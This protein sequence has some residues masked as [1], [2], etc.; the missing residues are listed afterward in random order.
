M[1][2]LA[3]EFF[4]A[5]ATTPDLDGLE[6]WQKEKLV[7]DVKKA[8]L[9]RSKRSKFRLGQ[10]LGP[11]ANKFWPGILNSWATGRKVPAAWLPIRTVHP[12]AY[13]IINAL[14]DSGKADVQDFYKEM[15]IPATWKIDDGKVIV[16]YNEFEYA[17]K[18]LWVELVG[19]LLSSSDDFPFRRC[20]LCRTIFVPNSKKQKKYCS[21]EC[22]NKAV[23]LTPLRRK[24]MKN[25]MADKRKADRSFETKDP[26]D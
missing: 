20:A 9:L 24:Y 21:K 14:V 18:E 23:S 22:A 7:A 4:A 15:V 19:L 25:Y 17:D 3:A 16:D 11:G 8:G 5:L 10:I 1:N 6:Q 12:W 2:R 13:K 26:K